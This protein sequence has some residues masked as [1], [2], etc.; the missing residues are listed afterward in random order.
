LSHH[1]AEAG[2]ATSLATPAV[3]I[4]VVATKMLAN[5]DDDGMPICRFGKQR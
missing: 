3:L 4:G 1:L 2:Y 5:I